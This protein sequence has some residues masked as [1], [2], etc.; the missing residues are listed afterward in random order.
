MSTH[1]M[2][3]V[4]QRDIRGVLDHFSRLMKV[5]FCFLS[6][7]GRELEVGGHLPH[8]RFCRLVRHRLGLS[9]RCSECDRRGWQ[10]ATQSDGAVWY[11][12]H[13]GMVDGC[14]AV[15]SGLRVLGYMMV[16][17][18][19]T[20]ASCSPAVRALAGR[21]GARV[22]I[23]RAFAEAPL[24]TRA[25]VRDI[26]GLFTVLVNFIVS[27]RL[28]AVRSLD[29]LDPLLTYLAEHPRE[30]LSTGDAAR[31]L[32]RSPSSL[33]HIFKEATGTSFLQHQ[34][35]HK[36]KMA[37]DLFRTRPGTTVRETAFELGFSDPYYF[38][39]LYRRHRGRPPT[40]TLRRL[41]GG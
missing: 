8:C 37:D 40:A 28:I 1:E 17:Q 21:D 7:D 39:R 23:D 29:P 22:E 6:A 26:M 11:R 32:H 14:M 3:F 34:I 2:R 25:Q 10:R 19:R 27:Q 31:L 36:L 13:A 33:A 12:C 18:F 35:A 41:R 24:Y 9:E 15:R 30:T 38:S 5:R 4:F 16:G 20:R